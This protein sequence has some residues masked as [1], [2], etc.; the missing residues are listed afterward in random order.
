H[1]EEGPRGAADDANLARQ[2]AKIVAAIN[3]LGADVV[4]L[5]E[6]E[7]SAKFGL[8]R[9]AAVSTLVDA[10][11]AAAG[12]GT[13][14]Y[15]PTPSNIGDQADE[16]VIRTAFIYRTAVVRPVGES[17][18]DDAP[19]F[20]IA[21]DPLAQAFQPVGRT[22]ASRFAVIVNHFKSKGSGPDDGTGQGNSNPQRV[23]QAQQLVTFAD[24]VKTLLRTDRLFLSGDFNAYTQ[25][26]PI[27]VL[28][29]AGYTDIG[30]HESPGEHT[31]LF[32]GVVGS[33]DHVLANPAGLD[34]VTGA[35]VWNINSVEPVALEY[36]RYNY[37]ASD[38]YAAD[39]FRAS[40]HDPL[41]VGLDTSAAPVATTTTADVSPDP[42]LT[43]KKGRAPGEVTVHVTS[44]E[45]TVDAGTV[46]VYDGATLIGSATVSA[47][48]V[49]TLTLP[50]YKHKGEHVLTVHYLGTPLYAP[51]QTTVEFEVSNK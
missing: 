34:T 29:D 10:L 42:V 2:Q 4:S 27:K 32:G 5:E 8:P 24:Q 7:N 12:A 37:N 22:S 44:P 35:H 6:I 16:D 15:V 40:D 11:N 3:G 9:D 28:R 38:F 49:A 36:S 19:E 31:Y 46:E 26:D 33:L 14:R 45:D 30:S 21:R 25:E 50:A 41:L 51:S 13:W 39:P 20:D 23:A 47:E 43:A 1:G 17:I 48:G 18:V